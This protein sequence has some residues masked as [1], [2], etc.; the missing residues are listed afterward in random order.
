MSR[1]AATPAIPC[2]PRR[3][4]N[5]S[6]SRPRDG[7]RCPQ[8]STVKARGPQPSQASK[9]TFGANEAL[10]QAPPPPP[11]FR[12]RA[13]RVGGL[14]P[15]VA[16]R[17]SEGGSQGGPPLPPSR[18]RFGGQVAGADEEL[19]RRLALDFRQV[20]RA[21]ALLDLLRLAGELDGQ[22]LRRVGR[23]QRQYIR[24]FARLDLGDD[25]EQHADVEAVEDLR[26][27]AR[28]HVL[29]HGDKALE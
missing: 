19:L 17:A 3:A 14:N 9:E 6:R 8:Q 26:R 15:A 4:R 5:S 24:H 16:R 1:T 22:V 13:L 28:L 23:H 2:P 20:A 12:L 18:V 11:C 25:L 7:G 21:R 29:V 27:I 10:S